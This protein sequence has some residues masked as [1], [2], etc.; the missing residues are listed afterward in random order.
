MNRSMITLLLVS[1]FVILCAPSFV[2]AVS[3]GP[4]NGSGRVPLTPPTEAEM[5]K[6]IEERVEKHACMHKAEQWEE[7]WRGA[8]RGIDLWYPT[9]NMY[10]YDVLFYKID[11]EV[12]LDS[13]LIGGYVEMTAKSL[14][15]GL[16]YVDLTLMTD[17]DV[18]AVR[19]DGHSLGFSHSV[20]LLTVNLATFFNPGEE[21]TIKIEYNGHPPYMTAIRSVSRA[22]SRSE[23][24]AGGRARISRSTRRTAPRLLSNTRPS[25]GRKILTA[26]RTAYFSLKSA[27][28]PISRA[29]GSRNT[30]SRH[31]LF[32]FPSAI[33]ER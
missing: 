5:Q 14:V 4:S 12:D 1:I 11:I 3:V 15:E 16:N 8:E 20:E 30:R 27:M 18:T 31:T 7:K 32:H 22:A 33:I 24:E 6:M 2:S 29:T 9:E 28:A 25:S 17:L 21:F 19:R 23:Q 13:E 26:Y 10:D